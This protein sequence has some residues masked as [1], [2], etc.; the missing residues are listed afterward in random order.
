MLQCLLFIVFD[1]FNLTLTAVRESF[2]WVLKPF[3][4]WLPFCHNMAR[5]HV[6]I[7]E[8]GALW[9]SCVSLKE[10]TD[11][12]LDCGTSSIGLA[13][14]IC[15]VVYT[16]YNESQLILNNV[17]ENSDCKG[18]LD[19][20]VSPPVFRFTFPINATNACSSS[21]KVNRDS[22]WSTNLKMNSGKSLSLN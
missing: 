20:L 11:I 7:A 12:S 16:G 13:I 2:V 18:T 22:G 4:Y 15:P 5:F 6:K 9:R 17:F 10:Y 1:Y 21:F 8:K 14:Q 3:Q 19:E